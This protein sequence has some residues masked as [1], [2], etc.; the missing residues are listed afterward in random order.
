MQNNYYLMHFCMHTQEEPPLF[1]LK[2]FG[3]SIFNSGRQLLWTCHELWKQEKYS[4]IAAAKAERTPSAFRIFCFC[5][6]RPMR[7]SEYKH[8]LLYANKSIINFVRIKFTREL[9]RSYCFLVFL[10]IFSLIFRSFLGYRHRQRSVLAYYRIIC[11]GD[12]C[13]FT[14]AA[15]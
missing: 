11:C 10:N 13:I 14:T 4:S 6:S 8:I 9:T 12:H 15:S 3:F 2:L 5:C 7:D 1:T